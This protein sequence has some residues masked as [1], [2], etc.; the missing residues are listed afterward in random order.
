MAIVG[1][2]LD[3]SPTLIQGHVAPGPVAAVTP[4]LSASA[5][6]HAPTV[7]FPDQAATG[8]LLDA[9]STLHAP[10]VVGDG[11]SYIYTPP[12]IEETLA[13]FEYF[14]ISGD[15]GQ[16]VLLNDGV[17]SLSPLVDASTLAAADAYYLGGHEYV[18]DGG[19]KS[20]IEAS[21]IGGT[22]AVVP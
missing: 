13:I 3:A 1:V 8:V 15:V 20:A 17:Y 7:A 16:T 9:S 4:L 21:G 11:V 22:F 10:S 14:P 6:L 19:T 12:T 2:L 5:A 18:V